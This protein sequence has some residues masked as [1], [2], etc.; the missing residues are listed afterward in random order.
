MPQFANPADDL[1][2]GSW[3]TDTN[4]STDLW[5][6]LVDGDSGTFVHSEGSPL[7]SPYVVEVNLLDDPI[8]SIDH[9]V[10]WTHRN[11][12]ADDEVELTVQLRQGYVSEASQ[13][14]LIAG[15]T[16]TVPNTPT[17]VSKTLTAGQA[18]AITDYA[19]L[20]LRFVANSP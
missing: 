13:G 11:P 10:R 17:T 12:Q 2:I 15:W 9:V 4:A 19:A 14:T 3:R 16:E 18:D 5:T 8:S 6:T 20:S 1:H 7:N